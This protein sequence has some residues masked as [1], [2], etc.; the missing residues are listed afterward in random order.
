MSTALAEI[1]TG[2]ISKRTP[3][4]MRIVMG[5]DPGLRRTGFAFITTGESGTGA[6]VLRSAGLVRL[7]PA[8]SLERRL[9][10]LQ[11]SLDELISEQRPA[12][13]AC[14]QLY[15]HY[16]HP[17]TAILM[18]HARG[19]V[20]AL[21]AQR[22]LTVISV[23]ATH[24]KKMITGRGHSGKD[25]VQ[26]AVALTLGL[27]NLPEPHDVADAIAIAIAGDRLHMAQAVREKA[28]GRR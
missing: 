13:L 11:S 21:A 12:V 4:R 22:G 26:R 10:M 19:V 23:P 24:A 5:V 18:G 6:P 2:P 3:P 14:E 17:R 27:A 16:K 20:L 9:F 25:A 8:A 1:A 28:A 15:A 7:D